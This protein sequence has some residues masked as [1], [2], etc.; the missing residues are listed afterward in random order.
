MKVKVLVQLDVKRVLTRPKFKSF[1]HIPTIK[2]DI[3]E[4]IRVGLNEEILCYKM[5]DITLEKLEIIK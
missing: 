2:R 5:P 4:A 3:L 1:C